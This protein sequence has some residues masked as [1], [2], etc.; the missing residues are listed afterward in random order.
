MK[1]PPLNLYPD[2][3]FVRL[4]LTD[5]VHDW[6]EEIE[7]I[8]FRVEQDYLLCSRPL[9]RQAGLLFARPSFSGHKVSN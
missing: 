6:Q 2:Q 9:P 7:A 5:V 8:G 1:I 4:A 3:Y